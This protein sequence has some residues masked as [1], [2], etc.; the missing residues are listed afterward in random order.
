MLYEVITQI[1]IEDTGSGIPPEIAGKIF[2]PFFT[3]K[4]VGK[5]TGLG[6]VIT[7]YSIHYTKLYEE[8]TTFFFQTLDQLINHESYC[9][10]NC[11]SRK[12]TGRRRHF[13]VL[14]KEPFHQMI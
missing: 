3:T 10:E 2:D 9:M 7:S 1:D 14:H 13:Y 12:E 4:E 8:D 5:G 6:I 11:I